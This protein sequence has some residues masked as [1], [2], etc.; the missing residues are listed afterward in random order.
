MEFV[1]QLLKDKK[2]EIEKGYEGNVETV[3]LY[4]CKLMTDQINNAIKTLDFEYNWKH[5]SERQ[6]DEKL[7]IRKRR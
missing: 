1:I 4:T 5:L 2:K 3:K 7:G 6:V